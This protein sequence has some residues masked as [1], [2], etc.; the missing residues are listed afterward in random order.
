MIGEREGAIGSG[1]GKGRTMGGDR[2][3]EGA[4]G[5]DMGERRAMEDDREHMSNHVRS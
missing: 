2:G 4:M 1:R 5:G 3:R